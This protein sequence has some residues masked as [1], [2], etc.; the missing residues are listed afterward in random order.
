VE[1]YYTPLAGRDQLREVIL[2]GFML[3]SGVLAIVKS[4]LVEAFNQGV[5]PDALV[6]LFEGLCIP[7]FVWQVTGTWRSRRSALNRSPRSYGIQRSY[8]RLAI[9]FAASALAVGAGATATII[10]PIREGDPIVATAV[11]PAFGLGVATLMAL[12]GWGVIRVVGKVIATGRE[13]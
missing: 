5:F 2:G 12:A 7:V 4:V 3:G 1:F 13:D 10:L 8:K 6:W 9:V 11:G